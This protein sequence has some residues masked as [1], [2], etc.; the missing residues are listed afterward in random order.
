MLGRNRNKNVNFDRKFFKLLQWNES[1]QRSA[2]D[3]IEFCAIRV[4]VPLIAFL[5]RILQVT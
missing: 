5:M 1:N 3:K 2:T 4:L